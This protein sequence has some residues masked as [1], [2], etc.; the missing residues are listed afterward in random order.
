MLTLTIAMFLQAVDCNSCQWRFLASMVRIKNASPE[1]ALLDVHS[2]RRIAADR[3]VL[4]SKQV[5]H[6]RYVSPKVMGTV[7]TN[8][9]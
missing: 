4:E 5:L 8:A 1:R 3:L 7:T 6:D 9:A 2:V